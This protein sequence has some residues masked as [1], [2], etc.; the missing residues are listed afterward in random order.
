MDVSEEPLS[1]TDDMQEHTSLAIFRRS[2][3]KL[4]A[5]RCH[6]KASRTR[7]SVHVL[8]YCRSVSLLFAFDRPLF[9]SWLSSGFGSKA[10]S[11]L[12]VLWRI[13]IR[14]CTTRIH[15]SGILPE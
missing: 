15:R 7:D 1:C 6:F 14:S 4:L 5:S 11:R 3:P 10:S 13:H 9:G 2:L 8:H 12:D